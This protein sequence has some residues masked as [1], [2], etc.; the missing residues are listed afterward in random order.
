MTPASAS[1]GF[2]LS[3]NDSLPQC[4]A[5]TPTCWPG[6]PPELGVSSP[7]FPGL[8]WVWAE[9]AAEHVEPIQLPSAPL[10]LFPAP[11]PGGDS[12]RPTR[13][14]MEMVRVRSTEEAI[15][16]EDLRGAGFLPH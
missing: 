1:R 5:I 2:V 12:E 16:Q 8:G 7:Q 13:W 14:K 6:L 9:A 4:M 3:P 10:G 15:F 11:A